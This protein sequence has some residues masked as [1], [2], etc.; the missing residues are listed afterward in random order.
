MTILH[1]GRVLKALP[2]LLRLRPEEPHV[3]VGPLWHLPLPRLLRPP[4]QP[5]RAHLVCPLD[6]SRPYVP[7]RR[8]ARCAVACCAVACCVVCADREGWETE[9]QWDQ[10]RVMKVGGNDS[11]TRFFQQNGGTASL[12]SKD[13]KTK[14]QSAAATKYK[15]EL[16]KRA[17]RDAIE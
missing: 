7:C 2:G 17:A 14:Y 4:P 1:S 8:P 10:L 15:E 5:R 12:N 6:Q 11:A 16:K 3:D 9:W 13:P